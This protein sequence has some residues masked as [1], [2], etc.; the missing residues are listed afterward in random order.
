MSMNVVAHNPD[1]QPKA[2]LLAAFLNAQPHQQEQVQIFG[3]ALYHRNPIR[4]AEAFWNPKIF[5]QCGDDW[6]LPDEPHIVEMR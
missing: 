6:M 2:D 3:P 1:D 4:P 5:E